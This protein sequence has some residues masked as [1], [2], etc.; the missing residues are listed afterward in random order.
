MDDL[1][2]HLFKDHDVPVDWIITPTRVI[3][4]SEKLARPRTI[5]WD[6]LSQRR[7]LEIPILQFLRERELRLVN[8]S[9]IFAI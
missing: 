6:I 3:E 2:E 8:N 5:I 9:C 4:V 1:P 7:V